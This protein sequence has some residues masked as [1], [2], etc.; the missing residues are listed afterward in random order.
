MPICSNRIRGG[1][2]LALLM[3]CWQATGADAAAWGWRPVL[4]AGPAP[5]DLL[6]Q[7]GAAPREST[8]I[9]NLIEQAESLEKEWAYDQ[10]AKQWE[11]ILAHR[12]KDLG[13]LQVPTAEALTGLARIYTKQGRY[14]MAEPLYTKAIS[15]LEKVLGD[16]DIE[17]AK[18][19]ANLAGLY[20]SQGHY[21][22]AET[23]Y[24]RAAK[25]LE[26]KLDPWSK[27]T[28]AS[29]NNLGVL[30]I[31]QARY[32]EAE[33]LIRRALEIHQKTVRPNSMATASSLK[34]LALIYLGTGRV[35]EAETILKYAQKIN[36]GVNPW[37]PETANTLNNLA[38]LYMKEGRYQDAEPLY[39]RALEIR[40]KS[41]GQQHPDTGTS[42]NNLAFLYYNQGR[43]EQAEQ[44]F[45]DALA[46]R[47]KSFGFQH[48]QTIASLANLA[49]LQLQESKL[50]PARS[51]LIRVVQGQGEWLRRELPLQPRDLRS[52]LLAQQ[53]NAV[54]LAFALLD[55][56][57]SAIDL[58]METRLNRQG[59]LAEIEQ[60]QRR[61]ATSASGTR[62]LAER[63]AR[64]DQ[65]VASVSLQAEKRPALEQER[66]KLEADLYRALPSL[67]IERVSISQ[68]AAA[69]PRDG[70]L[71]EIQKYRPFRGVQKGKVLW[72]EPRYVALLL[73][74]NGRP[75]LVSLRE[76]API[77][78]AVGK[79][80]DITAK[81]N[82]DPRPYWQQVSNLV[83]KPL[84]PHLGGIRQ[85]FLSSDGELHR[86][87]FL[88]L[89]SS[90]D[91]Q[92]LLGEVV[93]L[94][95]L[96]TGRDLVRLQQPHKIGS[97][98]VV[99]ANPAFS[100]GAAAPPG[101]TFTSAP[102]LGNRGGQKRSGQLREGLTWEPL[103]GTRDEAEQV[104]RLL[105]AG[106][107][108][109]AEKATASRALQQKGP[110][111][112]HIATHGFF[113]PEPLAEAVSSPRNPMHETA[114]G[115]SA[116]LPVV[117][118]QE[119]ALLRGG[120]VLAGANNPELNPADDGYLTAAEATGMDLE[121]TELVTLS[122]CETGLGDVRS[123]E[124]VYGLQR[125]FTVA[126]SR[127]TLLSLWK[128][129]DAATAAFMA[130]YYSR[131]RAGLGRSEALV[132][133]QAAFRSHPE[134]LYR[135]M[136]VWGAF[137]LTGDWQPIQQR[138]SERAM[139]PK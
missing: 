114:R 76:A 21:G 28:A 53:Q 136:Y 41:Q 69:L 45:Q 104:A 66:Q 65:L 14:A 10:A 120:L 89:P 122:A 110:R 37:D 117:A 29:L 4:P 35:H 115:Y 95:I 98:P 82:E 75:V 51:S 127:S 49:T 39:R 112:F 25:I 7:V 91:P 105:G 16:S 5:A 70:L 83:L 42:L 101:T 30:M 107:P 11:E 13:P 124:G 61:L 67:R 97:T 100:A 55:Q 8:R 119:D 80:L 12:E 38:E 74:P 58:A 27:T 79:A 125:A 17:T 31:E 22:L 19:I 132:A 52:R 128:V 33:T 40:Q 50:M 54:T 24:K 62:D 118:G 129:N 43:L 94:R 60:R 88:A 90:Q 1:G 134:P 72:G 121:G 131:L 106:A 26:D 138:P 99:M 139:P 59:L 103:P 47:Q 123:G 63:I 3:F 108:I 48:P 71:V 87:P 116:L 96:T 130:D 113:F 64:I 36:E 137:Q 84:Q 133:T 46:V 111:I 18:L 102:S 86:V 68:V 2:A 56:D 15:I 77:D 23:L 93:H 9:D 57:P 73:H 81:N 135:E 34:N 44:L 92:R 32:D 126:G 6:V 20:L 109:I 78:M 85:L